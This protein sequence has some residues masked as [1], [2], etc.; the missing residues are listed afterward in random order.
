MGRGGRRCC[1][2]WFGLV[3]FPLLL[4]AGARLEAQDQAPE[5]RFGSAEAESSLQGAGMPPWHMR[6]GFQIVGTK[7]RP[8]EQGTIEEWWIEPE[9]RKVMF[10]SPSFSA[11][12]IHHGSEFFRTT[13]AQAT[14]Y[15][16]ELVEQQI[17]K[18]IFSVE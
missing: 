10:T 6:V 8:A 4:S 16:L 1:E 5:Q 11:T 2:T 12:E 18:P 13:G 15:L 14:P 7:Q 3:F 9:E 17:V